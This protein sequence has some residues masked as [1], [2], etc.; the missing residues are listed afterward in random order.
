MNRRTRG[1]RRERTMNEKEWSLFKPKIAESI[2]MGKSAHWNAPRSEKSSF[3]KNN[4]LKHYYE[5][6]VS[7]NKKSVKPTKNAVTPI[8]KK[9]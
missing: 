1:W 7:E 5:T 4:Y 3:N 6:S 2:T 8:K 9:K